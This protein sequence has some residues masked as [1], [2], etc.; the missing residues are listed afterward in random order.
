VS[1][2]TTV[3]GQTINYQLIWLGELQVSHLHWSYAWHKRHDFQDKLPKMTMS[4]L[5]HAELM[6]KS[7]SQKVLTSHWPNF[8]THNMAM[9]VHFLQGK[10]RFPL[11]KVRGNV[12]SLKKIKVNCLAHKVAPHLVIQIPVSKSEHI[13]GITQNP[14]NKLSKVLC[15]FYK[16]FNA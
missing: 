6:C 14:L 13:L 4:T 3:G 7:S 16:L 9:T 8:L 11:L 12:N 10:L 1:I 2:N 5:C 15:H